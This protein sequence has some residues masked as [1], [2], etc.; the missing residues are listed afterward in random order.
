MLFFVNMFFVE[1]MIAEHNHLEVYPTCFFRELLWKKMAS[2]CPT[3]Y[4]S[5]FSCERIG[6]LG[7]WHFLLK[8]GNRHLLHEGRLMQGATP[9]LCAAARGNV[10]A[11]QELLAA[12]ADVNIPNAH[13]QS[14]YNICKDTMPD[15]ILSCINAI[16]SQATKHQ[17]KTSSATRCVTCFC[18]AC[19]IQ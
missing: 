11:F 2:F 6:R 17:P 12:K 16:P 19:P 8:H 13:G 3:G 14:A 5:P 1:F 18:R 4:F 15:E 9:L 10:A 7:M